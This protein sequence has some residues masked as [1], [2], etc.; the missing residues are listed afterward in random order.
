MP[1]KCVKRMGN[2]LRVSLFSSLWIFHL[3]TANQTPGNMVE[4]EPSVFQLCFNRAFLECFYNSL[5][6]AE[7]ISSTLPAFPKSRQYPVSAVKII[8]KSF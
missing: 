1:E 3:H 5:N 6:V 2:R 8:S 4:N 7:K